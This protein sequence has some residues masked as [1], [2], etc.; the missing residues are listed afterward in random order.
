MEKERLMQTKLTVSSLNVYNSFF[1]LVVVYIKKKR[2]LEIRIPRKFWTS[3][4]KIFYLSLYISQQANIYNINYQLY[5][6]YV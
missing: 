6:F 1:L 5:R 3:R 4:K 2:F